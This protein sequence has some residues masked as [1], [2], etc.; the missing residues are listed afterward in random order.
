MSARSAWLLA[1]AACATAPIAPRSPAP[2]DDAAPARA[3]VEAFVA[4]VTQRDFARALSLLGPP[5]SGRYSPER[6][7]SDFD[8]EPLAQERLQRLA[9][10]AAGLKVDGD[11]ARAPIDA[12]RAATLARIDG[13]WKLITLE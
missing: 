10:A 5:W 7:A 8:A 12:E 4:A 3:A 1:A 11:R 6:L 9:R 2:V 13:R